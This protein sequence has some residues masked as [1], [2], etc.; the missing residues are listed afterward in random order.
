MLGG[1]DANEFEV[2]L[3]HALC[4]KFKFTKPETNC[5]GCFASLVCIF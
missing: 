2:N 3:A 1:V 5:G 4:A